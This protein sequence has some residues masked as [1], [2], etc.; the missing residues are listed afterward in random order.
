MPTIWANISRAW[1][2]TAAGAAPEESA[3]L[4]AAPDAVPT[5]TAAATPK[6]ASLPNV[7]TQ[8]GRLTLR[9]ANIFKTPPV[10]IFQRFL[11]EYPNA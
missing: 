11:R 9:D 6:A 10:E 1:A 7:Q 4:A 5:P 2:R 8:S 3:A